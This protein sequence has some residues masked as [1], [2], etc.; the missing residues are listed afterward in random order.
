MRK[1]GIGIILGTIGIVVCI[2]TINVGIIN[3]VSIHVGRIH[4]IVC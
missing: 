1:I 4:I 2:M 3:I